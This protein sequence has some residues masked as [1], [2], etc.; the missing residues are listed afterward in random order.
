MNR[1]FEGAFGLAF[2]FLTPLFYLPLQS[3]PNQLVNLPI[4]CS[5]FL[6]S[7]LISWAILF[8]LF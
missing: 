3:F 6:L 4:N 5:V 7:F 1:R 2:A 8:Y